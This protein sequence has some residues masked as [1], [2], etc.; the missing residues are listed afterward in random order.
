MSKVPIAGQPSWSPSAS[1]TR[2]SVL[3]LVA[4]RLE[5]VDGRRDGVALLLEEAL[6]IEDDPRVVVDRD[7]VELAVRAGRRGLEAR[8]HVLLDVGPHVVDRR[9]QALGREEPQAV[10][11]EPLDDVVRRALQVRADLVLERVVVVD[12]DLDGGA[13]LRLAIVDDGPGRRSSG[14]VA[15][16]RAERVVSPSG[17]AWRRALARRRG[18]AP[19]A[20]GAALGAAR[21]RPPSTRRRAPRSSSVQRAPDRSTTRV[22]GLAMAPPPNEPAT[23]SNRFPQIVALIPN[24]CQGFRAVHRAITLVR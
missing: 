6:A 9:E 22:D 2:P 20:L 23:E 11:G 14:L 5:L 21:R 8:R 18:R 12:V 10:P 19:P 4:E 16:V 15:L 7:E 3:H 1:G 17:R 24:G 13:R